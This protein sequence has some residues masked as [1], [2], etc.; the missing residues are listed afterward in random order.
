MTIVFS[1]PVW[2][3]GLVCGEILFVMF[4][5]PV[6]ILGERLVCVA[7]IVCSEVVTGEDG[8]FSSSVSVVSVV[9]HGGVTPDSVSCSSVC[10]LLCGVNG[11]VCSSSDVPGFSGFVGIR[12]VGVLADGPLVTYLSD[13]PTVSVRHV[14]RVISIMKEIILF[15]FHH[16]AFGF[17]VC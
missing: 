17:I 1:F 2:V 8:F 9:I 6:C 13:I 16:F 5:F 11:C 15:K 10:G 4:G 14:I 7:G 3:S 12:S